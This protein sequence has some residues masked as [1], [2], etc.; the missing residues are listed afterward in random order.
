MVK[1]IIYTVGCFF[2]ANAIVAQQSYIDS[3]KNEISICK[4]D[5]ACMILFGKTADIYSEINPDSAYYYA[6]KMQAIT[7][8]L[9]L[10]LEES[11]A[12]NQMGYALMNKG[13]QPRALQ[14]ILSSIAIG[15]DPE[16]EKNL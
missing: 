15:E 13:N 14:N 16:S 5:T 12:L 3:L 6:E 10:K 4:N 1:R 9:H 11:F 2:I 8:K 7:K